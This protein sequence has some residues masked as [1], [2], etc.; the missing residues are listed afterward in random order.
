MSEKIK[1]IEGDLEK[2]IAQADKPVLV[3]F[4][5][6]TCGPC[7]MLAPIMDEIADELSDQ[8]LVC[9]A[10]VADNMESAQKYGIMGVPTV[11]LFRDGKP[12]KVSVGLRDK[13]FLLDMIGE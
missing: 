4:Y 10:N 13:A 7:R 2:V 8:V 11:I 1:M 9:K 5:S 6:V 12:D 3:D